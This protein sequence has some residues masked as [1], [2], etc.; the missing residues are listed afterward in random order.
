M[1]ELRLKL[2][3]VEHERNALRNDAKGHGKQHSEEIESLTEECESLR[4]RVTELEA[5]V[6]NNLVDLDVKGESERVLS[7]QL[8][9]L[10][11]DV[12][13]KDQI[14]EEIAS[15]LAQSSRV[16]ASQ[17]ESVAALETRALEAERTSALYSDQIRKLQGTVKKMETSSDTMGN[18]VD[19]T[20]A[21]AREEVFD[22]RRGAEHS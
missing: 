21:G 14:R 4:T 7:E 16:V 20:A 10:Q 19:E 1:S 12:I 15:K 13:E 3:D 22:A 17:R 6:E 5:E 18:L 2:T 9:K 8:E 11:S